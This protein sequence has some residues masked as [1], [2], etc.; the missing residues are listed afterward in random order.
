[1]PKTRA[2]SD[3]G[4]RTETWSLIHAERAALAADLVNLTDEEWAT[5]SLC[6]GLTVREVLAHLTASAGLTPVRWLAGVIRCRFDF[7]RQVAMR[8]AEQ[9]GSTEA[10]TLERFRGILTSTTKPPLPTL[11]MLGETIVHGEDI[12]RPLGIHRDYPIGTLTRAAEYYQGS[13]LVVLAKGRIAGLRLAATDGPFTTGSGPLV[14]GPTVALI[15]AMTGRT[16]YCD[17]LQGDGVA[18]LRHR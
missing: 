9:L 4:R 8:L 12:R 16:A 18:A 6:T 14:S 17:E 7:D 1:M 3:L 5:P 15:M 13:D 2:T 10:E 11:A